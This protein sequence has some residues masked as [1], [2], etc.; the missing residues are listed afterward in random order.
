M[1]FMLTCFV[2]S[3]LFAA[4][5]SGAFKAKDGADIPSPPQISVDKTETRQ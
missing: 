3:F 1:K 4:F 2:L 5:V